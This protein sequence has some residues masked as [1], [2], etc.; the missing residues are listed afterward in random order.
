M[1]GIISGENEKVDFCEGD[2]KWT[3][4][5]VLVCRLIVRFLSSQDRDL[6]LALGKLAAPR[7]ICK[8]SNINTRMIKLYTIRSMIVGHTMEYIYI[9]YIY[10]YVKIRLGNKCDADDDD[11][12][13]DDDDDDDDEL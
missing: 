9:I 3:T 7:E 10:I 12:Y 5:F 2:E 4:L 1:S 8:T 13:D 6:Y 11:D